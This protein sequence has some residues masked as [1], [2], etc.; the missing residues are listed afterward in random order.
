MKNNST[1]SNF[2]CGAITDGKFKLEVRIINFHQDNS[3]LFEKGQLIEISGI[4]QVS[5]KFIF[6]LF[7]FISNKI[8]FFYILS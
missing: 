5:G 1:S 7:T 4:M 8:I 2:G 6:I 3:K